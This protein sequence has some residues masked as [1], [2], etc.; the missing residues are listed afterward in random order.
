MST[1]IMTLALPEST[2][3]PKMAYF[4]AQA[5]LRGGH[6]VVVAH[7]PDPAANGGRP[8]DSI[9]GVMRDAGV[10]AVPVDGLAFPLTSAVPRR[11]A[12]LAGKHAAS[13][14]IGFQQRDRSVALKAAR[15]AGLPGI[16]SAQN[17]HTFRG[18]WPVRRL[19]RWV[20]T[21]AVRDLANLIICPA[22]AVRDELIDS[23]GV[24]PERTALVPNGVDVRGFPD[25]SDEEKT[26]VRAE[27]DVGKDELMLI[28][29]GRIDTQKGYDVLLRAVEQLPASAPPFKL[30]I[31][32][33]LST[34]PTRPRM[35][36]YQES[37]QAFVSQHGLE[38]KVRF[39]GWRDDCPLLLR[40]ADFYVHSARWEGWPLAVVEAMS[41]ER[42]IV[43]TDCSG[44]PI[45]FVDGEH[46]W[47]VPTG[48]AAALSRAMQRIMEAS[49]AERTA[50]GGANRAIALEHYDIR[51]IGDR[52]VS[53]VEQVHDQAAAQRSGSAA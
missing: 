3:A 13:S 6:Q 18:V 48:D 4:F 53:L 27:F 40:A 35:Q 38:Q 45:G 2:G 9:L 32:G 10:E 36:R 5:L 23:F 26:Q 31:V 25:F 41:A 44:R 49:P 14:V 39:A 12:E 11:V 43:T 47:I 50:M 7:G 37:L 34:G 42:P 46:G 22:D 30:V 52:F 16:I 29:V 51:S 24:S 8:E 20:Y 19:K 15:M 33:G 21:Q 1:V 17:Q 28:S